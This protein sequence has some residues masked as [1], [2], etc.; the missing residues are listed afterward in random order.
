[1]WIS[2]MVLQAKGSYERAAIEYQKMLHSCD[3][4]TLDP[5]AVEFT[6]AQA[7]YYLDRVL[8]STDHY[9]LHEIV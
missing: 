3:L 9:L 1:M 8:M 5:F 7:R 6:V 2:G 4:T